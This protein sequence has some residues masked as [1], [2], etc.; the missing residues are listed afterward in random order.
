EDAASAL[1]PGIRG[2]ATLVTDEQ[3]L[4]ARLKKLEMALA[5]RDFI[6][7]LVFC[8][9]IDRLEEFLWM[10]AFGAPMFL[11]ILIYLARHQSGKTSQP[12][13]YTEPARM[14]KE[15]V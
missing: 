11:F 10:A 14:V 3:S 15:P 7:L 12:R 6:Y 9:V 2:M 5:Q 1:N 4:G 8:C 13:N